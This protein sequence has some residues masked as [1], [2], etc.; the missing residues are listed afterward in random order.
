MKR[1]YLV[2][3]LIFVCAI[4]F[5]FA[6]CTPAE[7][8]TEEP[9]EEPTEE[10]AEEPAEE[11]EEVLMAGMVTDTGGV[12]DQSFNQSAWEGLTRAQEELGLSAS[13]LE[14]SQ[15]ADYASNLDAMYDNGNQLIW[16]IGFMMADQIEE[17]AMTNPDANYAII[18][19]YYAEPSDNLI[20]VSFKEEEAS[21]MVG[22][23]AGKMTE[24]NI[25]GFVGGMESEVIN[26]FHYG[27]MAGVKDANPDCEILVQYA[28]DWGDVA[29]GKA[30]ANQMYQGGADIVFHAAGFTGN[31]VIEA[32]KESGNWAIGVD[33]DQSHL[34]PDNV[35]TSSMKRV[36]NAVFNITKSLA[37]GKFMGG[38]NVTFGLAEGGVDIAP[39]SDVHVPAELLAE[40]E[41]LKQQIIDGTITVP[42]G[43][44]AYEAQ[45]GM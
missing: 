15:E 5:T 41:E 1:K 43:P 39:T 30:I 2:I 27:Y 23:I 36:D 22:Y 10:P 17:A 33:K 16:G 6:G 13:Y 24:T 44:E 4:T 19:Y 38:T 35:L 14:S 37:D 29:K 3:A 28:L 18:D 9:A 8:P 20:A 25:V 12:N 34:A 45:Y 32:A 26:H 42:N 7:E 40:V 11:P 21:Y 31:G